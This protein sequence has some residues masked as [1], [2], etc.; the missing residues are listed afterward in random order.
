MSDVNQQIDGS[1]NHQNNADTINYYGSANAE[2]NDQGIISDIF[3][4]VLENIKDATEE[5]I[6]RPDGIIPQLK[7]NSEEFFEY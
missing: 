6:S 5:N 1:Y 2:I 3:Y 4:N 7:K